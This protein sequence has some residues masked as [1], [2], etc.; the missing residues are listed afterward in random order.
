MCRLYEVSRAGYYAWRSRKPSARLK[1]D[2]HLATR[3]SAI[4]RASRFTYGSPRIHQALR[5][6]GTRIGKK[7]AERLMY[8]LGIQGRSARIYQKKAKLRKYFTGIPSHSRGVSLVQPNQ[9]WVGD[10]TY[11]K[12]GT[13]WWYLAVVLDKFSRVVT[14]WKFGK[15]KDLELTMGA[16]NQAVQKRNPTAGLIFH[17]D[18]GTEYGA[19]TFRNH[20]KDLGFVQ[21]MNRP[22]AKMTD[23]AHMESFFHSMKADGVHG[24]KFA[25]GRSA[26]AFV[27]SYIPFYNS[28]R[29]HSSL[30]YMTP[31][32]FEATIQQQTAVY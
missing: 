4:H 24:V 2:W 20:L 19:F 11:L 25:D 15:R 22:V 23:N 27:R 13:R 3:I 7:R 30:N 6:E 10:I 17:T 12:V 32:E 16:F 14:G 29:L 5:K 8:W 31:L 28:K 26:A 21:S 1:E 9:V 18:R